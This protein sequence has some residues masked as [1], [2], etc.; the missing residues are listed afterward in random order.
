MTK[1]SKTL[2][3]AVLGLVMLFGAAFSTSAATVGDRAMAMNT[4][5][6]ATV[7][8]GQYYYWHPHRRYWYWRHHHRYYYW[9]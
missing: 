3:G 1:I 8:A 7:G 5:A 9:R 6:V 2:C 4:A